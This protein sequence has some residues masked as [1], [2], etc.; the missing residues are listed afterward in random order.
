ML[1]GKL[2]RPMIRDVLLASILLATAACAPAE[3]AKPPEPAAPAAIPD[4]V[5][6]DAMVETPPADMPMPGGYGP[7]SLEDPR[8]KE[9]SDLAISEIYKRDPT[10]ALVESVSAEMQVVAGLNYAFTIK[11]TGG[12]TFGV[13]VFR[14]LQNELTVTHY[15]KVS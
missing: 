2:E 6:P 10:R 5:T 11:M 13:T 3:P 9:A 15:E 8:V 4:P 14:S 1:P 7:A 12:A